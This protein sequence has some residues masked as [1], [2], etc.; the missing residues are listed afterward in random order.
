[1]KKIITLLLLFVGAISLTAR[2][3][4]QNA[5]YLDFKRAER[6]RGGAEVERFY[7]NVLMINQNTIVECDSAF[8]FKREN[9]A[10]LYGNVRITDKE[11]PVVTTASYAEYEGASRMAR[12]RQ[13]VVMDNEGTLLYTDFLDY[14]RN[15]ATAN[16]F[17]GGRVVDSLNVLTSEKAVY[18]TQIE[19]IT[20]TERVDLVNPD[21]H[22]K[23]EYL[24]Y[25][26]IP[27]TAETLGLT[28]VVSAEGNR[29]NAQKG[30]YY[31]TEG[32]IFRFYDGDAETEDAIIFGETLYYDENRGYY[33]AREDVSILYK[34][35]EIE[36]FGDEGYHLELEKYSR[37]YGRGL[38]Q[39]YLEADTL[40]M[41]A[42]TL[43]YKDD[44]LP[45]NRELSAFYNARIFKTDLQG[46]GDSIAYVFADSSIHL[47]RDPV[48]WNDNNQV[49]A[50]SIRLLIVD[51]AIEKAFFERNAYLI[52]EDT[53]Q[54]YNQIKGRRMIAYFRDEQIQQ[55]DVNGN[56]ESLYFDL[57]EDNTLRGMNLLLCARMIIYFEEGQ[58]QRIKSLV[59][60]DGT[61]TPPHEIDDKKRK[62]KDFRWRIE[63]KPDRR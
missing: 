24:I 26:T 1:M 22:M 43:I 55:L 21:Y 23:T 30:A 19:R 57:L 48:L 6:V 63:E 60:P 11:D 12:L 52:G 14:D 16:Y 8:F 32:G 54:N 50:D 62:L 45:A 20:F 4:N 7:G 38:V 37:M 51:E 31:E 17:N 28:N 47:Y 44:E 13:N 10:K 53:L 40:F 3:Q 15:T 58:L 46:R 35:D 2:A 27:K 34:K 56:G 41:I 18:E 33:E 39:K 9:M 29:L 49:T 61:F 42:D 36:L 5:N 59:K 25:R